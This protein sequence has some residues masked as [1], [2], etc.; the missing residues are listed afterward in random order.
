[1]RTHDVEPVGRSGGEPFLHLVG[2]VG[3]RSGHGVVAAAAGDAFIDLPDSEVIALGHG[4]DEVCPAADDL[5]LRQLGQG[6]IERI[7][8]QVDADA[9]RQQR[10]ADLRMDEI[11]QLIEFFIA[12]RRAC[13]RPSRKIPA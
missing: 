7:A 11:L 8:A 5:V 6:S 4:A 9:L 13:A 2:D 12:P 3:R 10:D 1:M